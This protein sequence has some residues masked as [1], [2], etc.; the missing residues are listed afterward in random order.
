[1][2][3]QQN[4]N[5]ASALTPL[6]SAWSVVANVFILVGGIIFAVGG[7][8]FILAL[9]MPLAVATF[10]LWISGL[11]VIAPGVVLLLVAVGFR[12]YVNRKQHELESLKHEGSSFKAEIL[13]LHRHPSIHLGYRV[14]VFAECS[15][16]NH[17]GVVTYV[18]S[19]PLVLEAGYI[20]DIKSYTAWVHV[21]RFNPQEYAVEVFRV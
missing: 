13:G 18:K 8:L 4:P 14:A 9:L 16:T 2:S 3:N 6:T 19:Q 21:N 10:A 15:Y 5:V 1:M 12:R 7:L 20:S 11:S 17:D